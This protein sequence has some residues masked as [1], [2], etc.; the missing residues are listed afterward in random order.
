MRPV[1][2]IPCQADFRAGSER[3][4]YGNNRAYI[5]AVENAGGLPILIPMLTDLHGLADLLPRLDG[6]L[7]SGGVDI[8][9][10]LYGEQKHPATDDIDK[11]L[12]T[13]EVALMKLALLEDIPI[14]GICR[15]MQ[16]LNIMLGGSLYQD[17]PTQLPDAFNHCRRDMPRTA[18]A[19]DILIEEGSLA[20]KAMGVSRCNINSLHHQAVKIPGK[21]VRLSG[22]AID[23]TAEILEV[24]EHRFAMGVQGHPEEI[25]DQVPA[26]ARLFQIF[27]RACGNLPPE[28]V[29]EIHVDA[30]TRSTI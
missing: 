16:L 26:F 15:G 17:I 18:L 13:F 5:H 27:V 29:M 7:F 9:P 11:Q 21:G 24:P 1:I 14:L 3:P 12:D 30:L 25:Y 23:G 6:V 22:R 10:A 4:I 28:N 19:H 8:Q 20:E 2:G